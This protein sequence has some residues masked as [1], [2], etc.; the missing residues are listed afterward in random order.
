MAAAVRFV[1]KVSTM[2]VAASSEA[3]KSFW[4]E[5]SLISLANSA[6][7]AYNCDIANTNKIVDTGT[8]Q[9]LAVQKIADAGVLDSLSDSLRETARLRMENPEAS[10]GEL[11]QMFEPPISKSGVNHR[12]RKLEKIAEDL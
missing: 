11:C 8:R 9:L 10:L 12:L 7:R 6:N 2:A 4:A 5:G 1:R 3:I